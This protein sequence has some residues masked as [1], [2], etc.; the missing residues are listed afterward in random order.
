MEYFLHL[1]SH[2]ASRW[3]RNSALRPRRAWR[4]PMG[5][6]YI[7]GRQEEGRGRDLRPQFQQDWSERWDDSS[8][9]RQSRNDRD[10]WSGDRS[11]DREEFHGD[12]SYQNAIDEE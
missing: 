2:D 11:Q 9:S 8:R 10:S 12:R 6:R 7:N 5:D 4:A 3:Q 1:F